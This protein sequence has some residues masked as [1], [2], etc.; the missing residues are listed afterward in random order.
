MGSREKK[1]QVRHSKKL[2]FSVPLFGKEGKGRF[3]GGMRRELCAEL[4]GQSTSLQRLNVLS[5]LNV[6]NQTPKEGIHVLI[7]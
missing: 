6:L 1:F 7:G 3:L 2:R 4:L 5:G